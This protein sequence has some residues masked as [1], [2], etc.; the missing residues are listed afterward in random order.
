MILLIAFGVLCAVVGVLI[1]KG[2]RLNAEQRALAMGALVAAND[3][4]HAPEAL[5]D[6]RTG[7]VLDPGT[8]R[9]TKALKKSRVMFIDS[10]G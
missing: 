3:P 2:M 6:V 5:I 4:D 8:R 1:G 9:Y 10:Q 7:E